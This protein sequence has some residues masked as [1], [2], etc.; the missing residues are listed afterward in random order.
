MDQSSE[1]IVA[2]AD[3]LQLQDLT[4]SCV[5]AAK[6]H[7]LDSIGCVLGGFDSP[8]SRVARAYSRGVSGQP[9]ARVFGDGNITTPD[10]AA[11]T[12]A[13]MLRYLDFNDTYVAG[14]QH[15]SDLIPAV[16][17]IDVGGRQSN[18]LQHVAAAVW[19]AARD[20][21]VDVEQLA[22]QNAGAE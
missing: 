10:V 20:V 15:P 5:R 7:L 13:V 6:T 4:P 3:A 11:F 14:S 12:N 2:Y 16:L 22:P 18:H 21:P 8:P 17:G 9:G 1:R 19:Q